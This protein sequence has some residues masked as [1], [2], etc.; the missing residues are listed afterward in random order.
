MDTELKEKDIAVFEFIKD[1][2]NKRG[3]PP[4]VREICAEF[5][6]RSTSTTHGI[7][8]RLDKAGY[9]K[10]DPTLPRALKIC[11]DNDR[12]TDMNKML[13]FSRSTAYEVPLVGQLTAGA[14]ILA[15]E[16]IVDYFPIPEPFMVKD[17]EVF[18]LRVVGDSMI[19]A[20]I[21][22]NDFILVAKQNTAVNRDI[23]VALIGDEATVKTY[24]REKDHIRLQPENEFYDPILCYDNLMILGK[25]VGVFRKV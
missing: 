2:V 8:S 4:T 25:V 24:Y 11:K 16:N 1:S 9:I 22:N 5:S 19:N 6:I 7:L 12:D 18:M 15:V 10:K 21:L 3:F 17:R 23:V 20:G 14:P 13:P